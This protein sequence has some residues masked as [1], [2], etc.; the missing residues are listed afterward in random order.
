MMRLQEQLKNDLRTAMK[1][2]DT[3][4]KRDHPGDFG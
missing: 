1:E 3:A 4:K 2:K